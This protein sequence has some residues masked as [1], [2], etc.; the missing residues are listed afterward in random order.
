MNTNSNEHNELTPLVTQPTAI[1]RRSFI[2]R[3]TSAAMVT[4]LALDAFKNEAIAL[5]AVSKKYTLKLIDNG[6]PMVFKLTEAPYTNYDDG[7]MTIGS[8]S[9]P[10]LRLLYPEPLANPENLNAV[11]NDQQIQDLINQIAAKD[12]AIQD[13]I[14]DG[15]YDLVA[16]LTAEKSDLEQ[17][18]ANAQQQANSTVPKGWQ[19]VASSKKDSVAERAKLKPFQVP[20][21]PSFVEWTRVLILQSRVKDSYNEVNHNPLGRGFYN[22]SFSFSWEIKVTLL[23]RSYMEKYEKNQA[24]EW[25]L[26]DSGP[27]PAT[28]AVGNDASNPA[29]NVDNWSIFRGIN[30]DSAGSVTI[31]PSTGIVTLSPTDP[32]P[33]FVRGRAEAVVGPDQGFFLRVS[34]ASAASKF[35]LK[36]ELL[37]T[38]AAPTGGPNPMP[39]DG[40]IPSWLE[41]EIY[42]AFWYDVT[43]PFEE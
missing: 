12:Q 3:T 38:G 40:N 37:R 8:H 32:E 6:F 23:S 28:T 10:A 43:E 33:A 35:T 1:T 39:Q 4:V 26:D 42:D 19:W 2:K 14:L 27:G 22:D 34:K 16:S 24:G 30:E 36:A 18:L 29:W 11:A 20:Q 31:N 13:A 25:V 9:G 41:A 7:T 17:Q 21:D 5:D 15:N